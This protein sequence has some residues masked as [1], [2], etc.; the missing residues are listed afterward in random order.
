MLEK[1]RAAGLPIEAATIPTWTLPVT[2]V[3]RP[4]LNLPLEIRKIGD[5]D[6]CHYSVSPSDRWTNPPLTCV[7]ENAADECVATKAGDLSVAMLPAEE[8]RK[9]VALA[10]TAANVA[11][12]LEATPEPATFDHFAA[13]VHQPA[14]AHQN[15]RRP[16]HGRTGYG[17]PGVARVTERQARLFP[18]DRTGVSVSGDLAT[19]ATMAADRLNSLHHLAAAPDTCS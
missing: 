2:A 7:R 17:R 19:A 16:A 15:G 3:P 1:A 14:A 11:K 18:D 8:R 9:V 4:T 13:A 6:R 12:Q 5:V 10:E